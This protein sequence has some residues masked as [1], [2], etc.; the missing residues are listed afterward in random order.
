[1]AEEVVELVDAKPDAAL[2]LATG[3]TMVGVYRALVG[4]LSARG[5]SLGLVRT[6]NLDEYLGLQPGS[7]ESFRAFMERHLFGPAHV[8]QGQV[9]FPPPPQP[10]DEGLRSAR[11]FEAAIVPPGDSTCSC[12]ASGATGTSPST[13]RALGRT[14]EP[15]RSSSRPGPVRTRCRPSGTWPACRGGP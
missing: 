12:S 1:M 7:E 13:S 10:G 11:A 4:E 6:F 15:G 3:S 9:S 14:R 8:S 2:G 5:K